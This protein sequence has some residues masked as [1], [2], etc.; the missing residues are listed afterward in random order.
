MGGERHREWRKQ[1]DMDKTH[2]LEI[3]G[4]AGYARRAQL[5]SFVKKTYGVNPEKF[6]LKFANCMRTCG[7][8]PNIRW[9]GVSYHG[10]DETLIRRLVE[11]NS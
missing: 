4:G 8:G 9:D 11:E 6:T 3:C 10:A 5:A 1:I 7:K 2:C